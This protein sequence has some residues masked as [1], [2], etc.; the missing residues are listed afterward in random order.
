MLFLQQFYWKKSQLLMKNLFKYVVVIVKYF[1]RIAYYFRNSTTKFFW[2]RTNKNHLCDCHAK[3]TN[4]HTNSFRCQNS[5]IKLRHWIWSFALC[6]IVCKCSVI[7]PI[8]SGLKVGKVPSA[9]EAS[10]YLKLQ[11]NEIWRF[12]LAKSRKWQKIIQYAVLFYD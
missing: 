8:H 5:K 9:T 3:V 10:W 1:S 12:I 11:I 6:T 7:Q 4:H 2:K